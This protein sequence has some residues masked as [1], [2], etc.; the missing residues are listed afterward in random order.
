MGPRRIIVLLIALVAAGGTAMY[1]RSWVEGQQANVTVV[2]P[3]PQ[4]DIYEVLVADTDLPAGTFIKPA[5]L[6]W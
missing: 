1:A 2:A 4:T 3:A 5:D 6:R